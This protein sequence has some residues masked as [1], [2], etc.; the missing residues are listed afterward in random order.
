MSTYFLLNIQVGL[1][2]AYPNSHIFVHI[3]LLLPVLMSDGESKGQGNTR[4]W[5]HAI[6]WNFLPAD[7]NQFLKLFHS[8]KMVFLHNAAIMMGM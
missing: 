8:V 6:I 2:N 4:S 7:F 5:Q 1:R 3:A